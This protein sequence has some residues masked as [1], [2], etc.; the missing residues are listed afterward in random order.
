MNI[1]VNARHFDL[2]DALRDHVESK[3]EPVGRFYDG[4]DDVH[5]I[6]DF[7]SG[8]NQVHIQLRGDN[9]RLDAR[10][11]S[12]DMYAAYDHAVSSIERQ[13]RKFKDRIHGHPHRSI[14]KNG[15]APPSVSIYV[16]LEQSGLSSD[17]I[18]SDDVELPRLSTQDAIMQFELGDEDH[19]VFYNNETELPSAVYATEDGNPQVVELVRNG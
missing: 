15:Q 7:S 13:L 8:T 11:K 4:I 10:A 2:T 1:E 14:R 18:L 17:I 5:V 9:L 19:L 16:P 6:L 12:H 3:L